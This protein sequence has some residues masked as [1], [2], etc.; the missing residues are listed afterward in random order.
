MGG[1]I[2]ALAG[3]REKALEAIKKIE[4]RK[5]GAVSYTQVAQVYYALGDMDSYF[6]SQNRALEGH[7]IAAA[8][9]MYSPLFVRARADPRYR[10]LVGKIRIMSGLAK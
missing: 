9:V 2:D 1:F 3:D 7:T 5:M 8:E 4:D 6:E 10:E